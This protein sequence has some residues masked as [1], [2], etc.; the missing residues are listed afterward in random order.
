M[1]SLPLHFCISIDFLSSNSIIGQIHTKLN[2][3]PIICCDVGQQGLCLCLILIP[4]SV[5]TPASGFGVF[6][7]VSNYYRRK[8]AERYGVEDDKVCCTDN[9]DLNPIGD[10]CYYGVHYPCSLFQVVMSM[11]HWDESPENQQV[12][13]VNNLQYKAPPVTSQPL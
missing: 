10:F 7:C 3:E 6:C 5:Y 9:A 2:N 1:V 8:V 13:T 4:F 11:R 12:G